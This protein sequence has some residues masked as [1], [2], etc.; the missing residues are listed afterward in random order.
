MNF[1]LTAIDLVILDDR[2]ADAKIM[3]LETTVLIRAYLGLRSVGN[4]TLNKRMANVKTRG[5]Q[6]RT[7]FILKT[8]LV[9]DTVLR[10]VTPRAQEIIW[11]DRRR[12]EG[13]LD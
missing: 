8:Q 6:R 9:R 2:A 12:R 3:G 7:A 13:K 4:V 5:G 10:K 11:K 1:A